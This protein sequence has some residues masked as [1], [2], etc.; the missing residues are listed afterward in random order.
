MDSPYYFAADNS[1]LNE[2]ARDRSLEFHLGYY[3]HPIFHSDGN[4]P[5]V[6]IDRIANRSYAEGF[7]RSRLPAFTVEEVNMLRGSA[8][9]LGLN[10]Y[11]SSD[12]H[13]T[14]EVDIG[15]PSYYNDLGTLSTSRS[16][17][18]IAPLC[19]NHSTFDCRWKQKVCDC[20]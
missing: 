20:Y 8:D 5:Q 12:A 19:N 11:S 1:K 14:D 16:R 10:H 7:R 3:A 15:E 17:V 2:E 18:R 9:Y 13:Y 4:Y 6:V